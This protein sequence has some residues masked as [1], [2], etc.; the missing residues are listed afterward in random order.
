MFLATFLVTVLAERTL[1]PLLKKSAEQPIYEGGPKWHLSKSGTPTMGGLAFL[2]AITLSSSIATIYLSY[3]EKLSEALSL[4]GCLV[5]AILN[6]LIGML[7]DYTK[8]KSRKN[9]GLTPKQKL[10]LQ[11]LAAAALLAYNYF[12]LKRPAT[13]SFSFGSLEPGLLYYPIAFLTLVGITNCANL[14]DGIDGLASGVAFAIG[15]SS[16]FISC[17]LCT[18]V[19]VI[20]SGIMGATVA[21]LIFNIHPARIFMG[22]TGSLFLGA[23]IA[24]SGIA[25]GNPLITLILGG[26]YCIEGASVILQ[27]VWY[28]ASH[29]RL[30]RMAPL[31]HH[32][33]KLGWSEN[34]ICIVAMI[35][36][37]LFA[38]PAYL[39]Y[40]P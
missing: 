4:L 37:L 9:A 35:I 24:A 22:D 14:T 6:A 11:S 27:V 13:L 17:A 21:F 26:I 20:S 7:D 10:A 36:T 29:K 18:D 8:L 38:I 25:M 3:T 15:A 1:I 34:R 39:V 23:L 33:E 28:K 30:F 32:M 16:F 31:H 12:V 40:L 5:Y 2:I 19:A